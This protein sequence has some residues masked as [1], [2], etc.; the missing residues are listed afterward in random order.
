MTTQEVLARLA[1]L[2]IKVDVRAD[3]VPVLRGPKE[4][5]TPAVRRVVEHHRA[6]IIATLPKVKLYQPDAPPPA[7]VV[8]VLFST[9]HKSIHHFPEQGWPVGAWW[10]RYQDETEWRGIEGTNGM[11]YRPNEPR[12]PWEQ[13]KTS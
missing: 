7:R 4:E 9:G 8:E 13:R 2:E 1:E 11:T 12:P 6:A 5:L 10:W 3:G